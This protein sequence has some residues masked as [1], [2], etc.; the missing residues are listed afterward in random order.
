MRKSELMRLLELDGQGLEKIGIVPPNTIMRQMRNG[1]TYFIKHSGFRT[2]PD[3][4]FAEVAQKHPDWIEPHIPTSA[5]FTS[6]HSAFNLTGFPV[7]V[8]CIE[9][10][11][12][13]DGHVQWS[14]GY[15]FST[16]GFTVFEDEVLCYDCAKKQGLDLDPNLPN[17]PP[18]VDLTI[19]IPTDDEAR[20]RKRVLRVIK[21]AK[22]AR[23][24]ELYWETQIE[25]PVKGDKK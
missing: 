2:Q 6:D 4:I 10:H 7:K 14:D 23:G 21:A 9:C 15:Y 11:K 22:E 12:L 18:S 8:Q 3:E 13:V 16:P 5:Q 25:V 24:A 1:W 19:P 17:L 20:G